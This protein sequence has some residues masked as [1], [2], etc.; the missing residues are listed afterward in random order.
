MYFG[1]VSYQR[2]NKGMSI[3]RPTMYCTSHYMGERSDSYL[4]VLLRHLWFYFPNGIQWAFLDTGMILN[5]EMNRCPS[6]MGFPDSSVGK[7]S[8]FNAGDPGSIPGLGRSA[9]EGIG[10]PL[11]YSWASLVTQVVKNPPAMWEDLASTPA[12]GRFPREGERLPT[13][14]FWPGE[15]HGLYNPWGHK[16][17][18]MTE[19]VSLSAR[20]NKPYSMYKLTF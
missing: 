9:G 18:G 13:P 8:A 11:Q 7:E 15:F 10:Y 2:W 20:R 5:R 16:D 14:V 19:R 6:K 17:L 1:I 4:H 12:L 3:S